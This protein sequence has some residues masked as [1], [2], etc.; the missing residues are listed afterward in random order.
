MKEEM[1]KTAAILETAYNAKVSAKGTR[2]VADKKV[3]AKGMR[4]VADKKVSAKGDEQRCGQEGA[5]EGD[6][7]GRANV[8]A[9]WEHPSSI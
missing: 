7:Q 2:S 9:A 8:R 6:K 3:S 4:S 5:G 1:L